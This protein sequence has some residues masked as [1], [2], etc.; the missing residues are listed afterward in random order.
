MVRGH[1]KARELGVQ[2]VCGAQLTVASPGQALVSSPVT[3]AGL[4]ASE[5]RGPGWGTETD[6]ILPEVRVTGRRARIPRPKPGQVAPATGAPATAPGAAPKQGT[7]DLAPAAPARSELVLLAVDRAGWAN[8]TRLLTSGRRRCDKGE[9]LVAWPEICERA[10]GLIAL[11]GGEQ[12]L[13]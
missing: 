4:H 8:L 11:W 2:L 3:I 10:S 7:L 6:E 5:G 9:S 13:L 1:V 12:S